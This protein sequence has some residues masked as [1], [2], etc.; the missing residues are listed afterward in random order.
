MKKHGSKN[1]ECKIICGEKTVAK[2]SWKDGEVKIN[3]TEEGK[4]IYKEE[5]KGCCQ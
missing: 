4:E 1:K 3:C 5:F 2:I